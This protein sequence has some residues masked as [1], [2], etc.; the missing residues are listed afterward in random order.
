MNQ[1]RL[2]NRPA[3]YSRAPP[4]LRSSPHGPFGWFDEVLVILFP[5]NFH[6]FRRSV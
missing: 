4:P 1:S 2:D 5:T 3:I 6:G